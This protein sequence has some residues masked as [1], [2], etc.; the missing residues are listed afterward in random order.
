MLLEGRSVDASFLAVDE[1][2]LDD[3]EC[4]PPR[5][6]RRKCPDLHSTRLMLAARL[7]TGRTGGSPEAIPG[8]GRPGAD[9]KSAPWLL[10]HGLEADGAREPA[11][12]TREPM[13]DPAPGAQDGEQKAWTDLCQ[14]VLASNASLYVE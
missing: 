3:G 1:D 6:V 11:A 10:S 4:A 12:C 7:V 9:D 13:A 14:M 5:A 2:Q 8:V